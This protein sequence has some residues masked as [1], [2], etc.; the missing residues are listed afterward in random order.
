MR[1]WVSVVILNRVVPLD[2]I[3][4]VKFE[5]RLEKGDKQPQREGRAS[6]EVVSAVQR[7]WWYQMGVSEEGE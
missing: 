6:P 1:I 2:L 7:G 4:Q 5:Q 3:K